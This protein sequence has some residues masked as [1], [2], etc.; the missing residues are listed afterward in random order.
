VLKEKKLKGFPLFFTFKSF[1]TTLLGD[2]KQWASRHCR[3]DRRRRRHSRSHVENKMLVMV[4]AE[5]GRV[6]RSFTRRR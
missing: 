5:K 4:D 6:V 3:C 2:I 1:Q